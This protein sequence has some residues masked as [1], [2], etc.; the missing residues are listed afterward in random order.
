MREQTALS[1]SPLSFIALAR[2]FCVHLCDRTPVIEGTHLKATADDAQSPRMKTTT[3]FTLY[4]TA[5][6]A[7]VLSLGFLALYSLEKT[8]W[9]DAR[10]ELAQEA[11]ALHLRLEANVFR[12]F[13]QHGDA[14]LIGDQARGASQRE[15]SA[16]ISQNLADLR[17][18]IAREIEMVGETEYEELE[19]LEDMEADI[20][21]V[22]RALAK[23]TSTGEPVQTKAQVARLADLLDRE[24]DIHLTQLIDRAQAEQVE[25]V[26][27]TMQSAEEYRARNQAFIYAL[28]GATFLL[29]VACFASF[30][31]Q[32]RRP[33]NRLKTALTRLRQADYETPVVLAGSR[34]F[35]D[36]GDVLNEMTQSLS[37]HEATRESHRQTL[38][39]SVEARTE[40][41]QQLIDRLETGE[42]SR[43]RLM[44]DI[45]HE[46]RTPLTI[47]LGEAEVALRN[48]KAISDDTAD[49]LACIRDA[50]KHT[51]QIV[52]DML[53]VARQEA[54]QLRLDQRN[55]DLRTVLRDAV[56]MFPQDIAMTVPDNPAP[57]NTD[58]VRIR[59]AILAL[60]HNAKRHGGPNIS[61]SLYAQADGYVVTVEDDGPGLS[62]EE[63]RLAFERFFRG[64]NASSQSVE[65]SGLGLPVVKSIIE[66][67]GGTV[68]LLDAEQGGLAVRLY[69]PR[70]QSV[71]SV[72][73]VAERKRA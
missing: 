33:L 26:E 2:S 6:V 23:I 42:E 19:L 51:N 34:E 29:L 12:L 40:E 71:R 69:L 58:K 18:V 31:L 1:T 55:V 54:G 67:H 53:T 5:F 65:G 56:D 70:L 48:S 52:D 11:H 13:K 35:R 64:S 62:T 4:A 61:A 28:L 3:L 46:L 24:I 7:L 45:S 10:I 9:W 60:F 73:D 30:N 15:L 50:A 43:K 25:D 14:L 66:A 47:I 32:I 59:Q 38:E 57:L 41:L 21:E 22:N 16:Q 8:R 68:T 44:A 27:E 63:K 37:E 20:R 39:A 17:Y 49:A 36:L 72:P